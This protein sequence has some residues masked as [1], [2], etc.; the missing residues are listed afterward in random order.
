[1]SEQRTFWCP[2]TGTKPERGLNSKRK[3]KR[4]GCSMNI[5][6]SD[7]N[8]ILIFASIFSPKMIHIAL[9]IDKHELLG[10][11]VS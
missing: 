10:A 11:F 1:M 7:S 2:S 4:M 3:F 9:T 8:F 5:S 6:K